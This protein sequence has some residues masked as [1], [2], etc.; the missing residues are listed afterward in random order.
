MGL[1][2]YP[3]TQTI[4]GT[5]K[6]CATPATYPMRF[7]LIRFLNHVAHSTDVY[8]PIAPFL[9]ETLNPREGQRGEKKGK[10]G[11]SSATAKPPPLDHV[12][13][14]SKQLVHSRPYTAKCVQTTTELL[15]ESFG[16][17]ANGASHSHQYLSS[18]S[19]L[20]RMKKQPTRLVLLITMII[21]YSNGSY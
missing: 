3:Y 15:L 16:P 9:L 5:L 13:R 7:L 21:K 10:N 17:L 12:L 20:L 6:L 4:F 11:K 8:L 1:L 2:V 18:D 14:V 19:L